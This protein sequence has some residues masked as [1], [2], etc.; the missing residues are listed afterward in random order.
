M[1]GC[2]E[3][4]ETGPGSPKESSA[5]REEPAGDQRDGAVARKYLSLS[6]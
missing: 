5:E 4:W 1:E 2:E 3:V 6:R